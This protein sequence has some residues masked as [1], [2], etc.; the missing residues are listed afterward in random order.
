MRK[1]IRAFLVASISLLASFQSFAQEDSLLYSGIP[2][3]I[4]LESMDTLEAVAPKKKKP[5]KNVYYGIKTKRGFTRSGFGD[6]TRL[7]LFNYLPDYHDPDPYVRDV[8]W[9]DFRTKQIKNS[10]NIDKK[11]GRLL[12]GP[13][14]KEA[15]GLVLVEGIYYYGMKHGRWTYH[16]TRDVLIDKEKYLKGWPK[17]STITYYD[18]EER[19]RLKEVIPIEFG[20]KEGYYYYFHENG[21]VAVQG[22]YQFGEK[23]GVW[24]EYYD[25][26]RRRKKQI[27]Y[28]KTAFEKGF[29]PYILTEWAPSGEEIYS[30]K[31]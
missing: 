13:Y 12:H 11:Y 3:S 14:R 7:E 24:T 19:T 5:K 1:R 10:K 29:T 28:P 16:D 17:E 15:N 23:V 25:Q 26:R 20:K 22:E 4:D 21:Q 27:M 9:I 18:P 6:D 31:K 2:L 8:Y 30:Y